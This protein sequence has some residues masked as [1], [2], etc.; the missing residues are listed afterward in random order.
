MNVEQQVYP[1]PTILA[2]DDIGFMFVRHVIRTRRQPSELDEVAR[3]IRRRVSQSLREP[4]VGPT[5]LLG[6]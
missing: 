5:R 2:S 3:E 4:S 1:P 6:P